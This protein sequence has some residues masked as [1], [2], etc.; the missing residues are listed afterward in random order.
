MYKIADKLCIGESVYE[1]V[2]F[3]RA[4]ILIAMMRIWISAVI[5]S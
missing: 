2:F 5:T 3:I 4:A 1:T